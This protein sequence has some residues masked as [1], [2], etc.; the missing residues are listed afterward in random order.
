M[1]ENCVASCDINEILQTTEIVSCMAV[2]LI[3]KEKLVLAH[4]ANMVGYPQKVL[5]DNV[6][7]IAQSDRGKDF[8]NILK[9]QY[10]GADESV[11]KVCLMGQYTSNAYGEFFNQ[12]VSSDLSPE[13]CRSYLKNAF[14]NAEILMMKGPSIYSIMSGHA[15]DSDS[16]SDWEQEVSGYSIGL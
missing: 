1:P 9:N 2:A 8:F 10:L 4:I 14:P 5:D 6:H 13:L 11:Q 15:Y 12:G 7:F 3:G 16:F